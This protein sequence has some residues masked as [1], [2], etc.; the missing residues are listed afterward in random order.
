MFDMKPDAL[1]RYRGEFKPI[2][3]NVPGMEICELM[4]SAWH[5]WPTKYTIIRSVTT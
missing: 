2:K 5:A 3:T 1:R 4:P